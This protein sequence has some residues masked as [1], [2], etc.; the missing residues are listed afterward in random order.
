MT[1][2]L[3]DHLRSS[4][5]VADGASGTMLYARGVPI[6]VC[7]DEINQSRPDLIRRIHD[8]YVDGGPGLIEQHLRGHALLSKYN[9]RTRRNH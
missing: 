7:F 4:L 6:E 9:W 8:E 1:T 5:L 3:L 2:S